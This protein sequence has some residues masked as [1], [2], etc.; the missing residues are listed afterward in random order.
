MVRALLRH[1]SLVELVLVDLIAS[2]LITYKLHS[3]SLWISPH[4]ARFFQWMPGY[5]WRELAITT[6]LSTLV[7]FTNQAQARNPLKVSH[8]RVSHQ[9]GKKSTSTL[10][11]ALDFRMMLDQHKSQYQLSPALVLLLTWLSN[12]LLPL[13]A[14]L[15]GILSFVTVSA[16]TSTRQAYCLSYSDTLIVAAYVEGGF[17]FTWP[18]FIDA[19]FEDRETTSELASTWQ[20]VD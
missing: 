19:L 13:L 12:A 5:L 16:L 1:R 17:V 15:A 10:E 7:Y 3:I 4:S 2:S 6:T 14:C 8:P 11:E 20:T 18:R 9:H